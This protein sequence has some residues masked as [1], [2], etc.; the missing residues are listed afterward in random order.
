MAG[1]GRE[2][3]EEASEDGEEQSGRKDP[4]SRGLGI[5]HA[6]MIE[7]RARRRIGAGPGIE[8]G[9]APYFSRVLETRPATATA[10][11]SA[12]FGEAELQEGQGQLAA[13][14]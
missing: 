9:Q 14:S 1:H 7:A 8:P 3:E 10:S 4:A 6:E 2:G 12:S 5:G 13:F 11:E